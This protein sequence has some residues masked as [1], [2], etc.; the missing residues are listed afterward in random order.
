MKKIILLIIIFIL[1]NDRYADAGGPIGFLSYSYSREIINEKNISNHSIGQ[2]IFFG[3][4]LVY[5]SFN[6]FGINYK[7]RDMGNSITAHY[8]IS[9]HYDFSINW[10]ALCLT[11]PMIGTNVSYNLDKKNWGIG[12]QVDI[13]NLIFIVA[14]INITY[15]YNIYSQSKNSHELGFTV[16]VIDFFLDF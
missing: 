14:K 11:M 3:S 15:R 5:D 8:I 9:P 12:P 6:L 2:E 1:T 16:G 4:D 13:V 7:F 10:A